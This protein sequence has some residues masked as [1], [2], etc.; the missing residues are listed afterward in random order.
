MFI[1]FF[2]SILVLRLTEFSSSTN[3]KKLKVGLPPSGLI[4]NWDKAA[5]VEPSLQT[6]HKNS[7]HSPAGALNK[8][9]PQADSNP[10]AFGYGGLSSDDEVTEREAA[11][12]NI[13]F[14][15]SH[16]ICLHSRLFPIHY[17]SIAK[18]EDIQPAPITPRINSRQKKPGDRYNHQDLP[19]ETIATFSK[20]IIPMA[21]EMV[22]ALDPWDS[23][24]D[25]EIVDLWNL[26]FKN[27]NNTIT[28]D[29]TPGS[30]FL[31][32]KRLVCSLICYG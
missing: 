17:Q 24:I 1:I 8:E 19:A 12:S 25:T 16:S 3:S 4:P 18:I 15:V 10:P 32:V 6:Y 11:Q 7:G 27:T 2:I 21:C 14:R 22:G 20:L 31:V 5:P 29:L 26:L 23:L 30:L 9:S 13:Q 28:V